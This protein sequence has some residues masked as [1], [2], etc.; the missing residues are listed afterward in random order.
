[1]TRGGRTASAVALGALAAWTIAAYSRVFSGGAW[2][3]PGL[4]AAWLAMVLTRLALRPGRL[5]THGG[6]IGVLLALVG[7]WFVI[8][9]AFPGTTLAGLPTATSLREAAQAIH[10]AR[11]QMSSVT[12]PLR[13]NQGYLAIIIGVSWLAG[14]ISAALLGRPAAGGQAAGR[15][16]SRPSPASSA[17]MSLLAPLPWAVLFTIAAGVGAGPGRLTFSVVFF[18]ALLAYLLVEGWAERGRFPAL[19]R[20]VPLGM[21]SLVGA[22]ALPNLVPGYQS[23]PILPWA[24]IGPQTQTTVS[25]LVQIKPFLLN[26]S[27]DHLFTVT[28][29]QPA[30]WR[31]TSLDRFDGG[32]WS[33]EGSYT[34]ASGALSRPPA[35]IATQTIRQIYR[36]QTLGGIW[37]PAVFSPTQISGLHAGHDDAS[38]TLIVGALTAGTRYQVVSDVPQPTPAQLAAAG[39]AAPPGPPDLALPAQTTRLIAPIAQR[40]VAGKVTAYDQAVALQNYLRTFTYDD[41]VAVPPAGG[42]ATTYL[43][44]FLTTIKAGYCEQFAGSMAVMLRILGI[45]AR[46]AVGFLPGAATG[47]GAGTTYSVQGSDAH[48]W[49]EAYF[50]GVG[51]VAFEPTPRSDAPLPSYATGPQ[52]PAPSGLVTASPE[53]TETP[54]PGTGE[55]P[56]STPVVVPPPVQ[57]ASAPRRAVNDGLLVLGALL[58]GLV[59]GRQSRLRLP[60]R[61][62]HTPGDRAWAAY[63]EFALRAADAF[64]PRRTGETEAEYGESLVEHLDLP[65]AEVAAVTTAFQAAV[66][67]PHP[68]STAQVDAALD[69][70][71]GL[72][73]DLWKRAGWRGRTRLTLSARPLTTRSGRIPAARGS[74]HRRRVAGNNNDD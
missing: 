25:P 74:R 56:G 69:A 4:A 22:V 29:D 18:M 23:G 12:A 32:T 67:A 59:A 1:M 64:G 36:I 70:N 63:R 62:A 40:I 66:Y 8:L 42:S 60:L 37:V 28:A 2:F 5:Q 45:P 34:A 39:R 26:K 16:A 52:A 51:W 21:I 15:I 11:T 54:A 46:V 9:V 44:D 19:R 24:R 17:S 50:S 55:A 57:H 31:L 33:S 73:R 14:A 71:R 10:T 13:P 27:Y 47:S 3:L 49:P 53:P 43:Y 48:A 58:V 41:Q 38:Q 20:A 30:Y 68:P 72:R 35:G 6:L 7:G 61:R 65:A